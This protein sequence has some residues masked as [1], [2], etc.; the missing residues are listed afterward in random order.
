MRGWNWCVLALLAGGAAA[1][2]SA[3]HASAD[4]G[5]E[6]NWTL[7][8]RSFDPCSSRAFLSPAN[9][10]RVNL[11]MLLHDRHGA[12]GMA[13][14]PTFFE[15]ER[16]SNATGFDWATYLATVATIPPEPPYDE[17]AAAEDLSATRCHSNVSGREAFIAALRGARMSDADRST[18]AAA[19]RALDPKCVDD[20]SA[21][22]VARPDV[23]AGD[24]SAFASY[25]DGAR[26]FYRGDWAA[27]ARAFG[28]I[29]ATS[30]SWL[31]E[32]ASYM[33]MRVAINVA[34]EGSVDEW[35]NVDPALAKPAQVAAMDRALADYLRAW[36]N[37]RYSGSAK[38]LAR[39]ADW[40]S[41]RKSALLRRYADAF[42]QGRDPAGGSLA[43]LV[44]EFDIKADAALTPAS[45]PDA[46]LLAVADLRAMRAPSERSDGAPAATITRAEIEGQA[47]RFAGAESLYGYV[48]AA[49][50]LYV[51]GAPGRVAALIPA[52]GD[53][54]GA[55]A[56]SRRLLR[57]LA[58]DMLRGATSREQW[59]ALIDAADTPLQRG[60]AELGLAMFEE[61]RGELGRVFASGSKVRDPGIR[62]Q[63][64]SFSAGPALLEQVVGGNG[65]AEE[66]ALARGVWLYKSLFA[67]RY[68]ELAGKI[69]RYAVAGPRIEGASA[70]PLPIEPGNFA[71]SGSRAGASGIDCPSLGAVT[72]TLAQSPQNAGA[73][74]CLGEFLRLTDGDSL[75]GP[76][77]LI[78]D[79]PE[80]DELGGA[81]DGW[82]RPTAP[83]WFSRLR[84][85]RQIIANP[86]SPADARAYALYR[87]YHCYAP[88]GNNSCDGSQ[89]PVSQR[90]AWF[91]EL[92][93]RYPQ[94]R[95][96]RAA[97]V[98]W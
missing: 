3:A 69:D 34:L 22:P 46:M 66:R 32:A 42:A 77:G 93:R 59:S 91:N 16:R 89:D 53:G 30:S 62:A 84:A 64:I 94:T 47:A 7:A 2:P 21:A 98:Y 51:E 28:A 88:S 85:Y 92:K 83:T 45:A 40:L 35:G 37:G 75:W 33:A 26:A 18:L 67:G 63:L 9:D 48:K 87:A 14:R 90:R 65:T 74:L 52:S 68:A 39:R 72:R 60:S 36:P 80:P 23:A 49:H 12:L 81:G 29:G 31:N 97:T 25:L 20:G 86:A 6:P 38:G 1:F 70:A 56:Y 71:W 44:Q 76:R 79:R 17:A 13:I 61:R 5:C 15:G 8:Q 4:T 57:T 50:A 73:L 27:A 95:W 24:A 78:T 41:G 82:Q 19:R 54:R 58:A 96:A 55:V 43:Q 11:A 10:T